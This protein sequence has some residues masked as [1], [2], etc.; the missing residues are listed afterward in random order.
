[1]SVIPIRRV[2]VATANSVLVNTIPGLDTMIDYASPAIIVYGSKSAVD[3]AIELADKLESQ[4]DFIVEFVQLEKELP[5]EVV[6]AFAK[7]EPRVVTSYDR[8][9][10]KLFLSG[11][12]A[13][14]A[15]LK[16][17]VAEI[18]N[19]T[20][21]EK[22]GVYYLDVD[23]ELPGEIQDYIRR[24]VPGVELNFHQSS[25]RFTIIGTPTEQLATA[26]LITD[27][28]LNLP[29]EDET[30]YYKL[31][32]QAP[33]RLIE[34]LR[35]RVKNVNTIERDQYNSATLRVVAK[36]FQHE[37]IAR[38]LKQIQEEYPLA[39]QNYFVA[40]K[41]TKEVRDR[42]EQIKDDWQRDKGTIK[43]LKDDA[44]NSF[45]VWA[46]PAQHKALKETLEQL[47]ELETGER[48]TA[49]LYSP[50]YVDAAT[51]VTILND[52]HPNVK[53]TNDTLNARIILR[54]TAQELDE[55]KAT[56]ATVDARG[57]DGVERFFKSYPVQGFYSYDSVGNYFSP[58]Y[59]I[60]DLSKL[61]PA[62][63]VTYDYYNQAVVVWGT[64]E[65]QDIMQKAIDDLVK[66]NDLDKR[67]LRWPVRRARYAT[68]I[69]Q[70]AA[71]Y[72]NAT[73]SYDSASKT[74][75]VRT[76][77]VVT[78]D[79]VKELLEILDPEEISEF[80]PVLQYYDVGAAPSDDLV[81]A[82]KALAPAAQLVQV[83]K[84]TKQLLVIATPAEH[85]VVAANV[86]RIAKTFGSSDLRLIPYPIYSM[87]VADVVASLTDAYP[88]A[89]FEADTRG[90]RVLARATLEDHVKISEEIARL[91]ADDE[92]IDET[93]ANGAKTI[94]TPGPRV[95]VYDLDSMA[96]ATQTRGVVT[97]LFPDAEIFGGTSG[98]G[99]L[100]GAP[101]QKQKVTIIANSREQKMIASIIESL[102]SRSDDDELLFAI[103]PFAAIDVDTIDSIVGNLVPDAIQI[104]VANGAMPGMRMQN[105]QFMMEQRYRRMNRGYGG[106]INSDDA[107]PFY[108]IDP[109][110]QTVALFAKQESHELVRESIDKL[111]ATANV[112]GDTTTK[113]YRLGAPIASSVAVA[114]AQIAPACVATATDGYELIVYGPES[115]FEKIDAMVEEIEKDKYYEARGRMKLFT[116]PEAAKYSRDRMVNIINANFPGASAYAGAVGNQI[117][118]WGSEV[119]LNRIENFVNTITSVPNEAVYKTYSLKHVDVST[120]VL[121]LTKVCPNLEI[122]PDPARVA[123]VIY[124][125][126]LQHSEVENAIKA[127]DQPADPEAL[128]KVVSY[129]WDDMTSYWV[130]YQELR[131]NFPTISIAP[132]PAAQQFVIYAPEPQHDQIAIYFKERRV[133][134]AQ[135]T[136]VFKPYYLHNIGYTRLI[137]ITPSVLPRVAI[138]PGKGSNEIFV[139]ASELD[140]L[141]FQEMLAKMESMPTEEERE[142]FQPKIYKTSATAAQVAIGILAPQLPGVSMYALTG[143]RFIAWGGLADHAFIEKSLQTIG[144]AF[145]EAVVKKYPLI[146]LRITDVISFLTTRYAGQAAFYASSS[147]D[148]MCQGPEI[149]QAEV[150]KLLAELDVEPP[151]ESRYTAV[152]YDISDIP[153][154]SHPTVVA[155]IA[156]V[157]PEALQ[158]P[159]STPGFLVIYARPAHHKKI[160]E[161]IDELLLERP[162]ARLSMRTYSVRR[163]T[164]AQLSQLLLPLYPNIKIGAGAS[165]YEIIITAKPSEH[166]KIAELISQLNETRDDGMTAKV[167]RLKNSQLA[168]ARSAI[169]TMYPQ[170]TVVIDQ[171]SRSVLV[172]AYEDEHKK[173]EQLVKEIDEKDPERNTSFKV[174]NIGNI[175]FTRVLA[176]LQNFYTG[177]PAFRVELDSYQRCIIV[178]GTAIQHEAVEKLIEEIRAGGM[179]DPDAYMQAYTVKNSSAYSSLYSIFYEI[180]SGIDMYRDYSTGKLIVFGREDDHKLVQNVLDLLA[181]EDT[182]LAIFPLLYVD[183]QTARQVFSMIET[184][185]TYVDVRFDANSNQLFV[186]A[187]PTLLEQIRRVL[188][189]MGEKDLEKMKPFAETTK[190]GAA[191]TNGKR[192]YLRDNDKKQKELQ[193]AENNNAAEAPVDIKNL[194]KIEITQPKPTT[195]GE[196]PKLQVKEGDGPIRTVT[197]DGGNTS[198]IIEAAIKQWK[199]DNPVKVVQGDGGIVQTKEGAANNELPAP[200]QPAPTPAPAPAPAPEMPAPT[201][202][203]A[204]APEQPAPAPEQPV[205]APAP[206]PERAAS[207]AVD[208]LT[209]AFVLAARNLFTLKTLA[210]GALVSDEP[211]TLADNPSE[212]APQVDTHA[213]TTQAATQTPVEGAVPQAPGV[214]VVVNPD[215]SILLS[216]SDENALEE[217]Q[218][219]LTNVVEGMKTQYEANREGKTEENVGAEPESQPTTESE[220]EPAPLVNVMEA[221]DDPDSPKYL[222]YMTEENLAK[223]RERVL[224]ESRQYTVYKVENVGVSQIVPRLQTYLADRINVNQT[225]RGR[226]GYGYGSGYGSGYDYDYYGG[227]SGI[228][229]RTITPPTQLSFREDPALNT[230][231]VFGS[232]ADREAV[233]AMLVLLDDVNLFPQPITK[234]YKIKVENTSALRMAQQVLNAFSRKF[235]TTLMPGNLTPRISPN[236][237]TNSL[238]VYA[239]EELAKEIEEYVNEVDKEILEESVRKVRVIELKSINSKTLATYMQHLRQQQAPTG[240]L[241]TPYI[242]GQG[243]FPQGGMYGR[244]MTPAYGAAA[245]ARA[246]GLQGVAPAPPR[247]I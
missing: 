139:I 116:L 163:M 21:D 130:I 14:V 90:S 141:K 148:L 101:G 106:G 87:K 224:L 84:K 70:I 138:Y 197:I 105:R 46:L 182:E 124:G 65:E 107:V 134:N 55:A 151:E 52:L 67:L 59:Y 228:T 95:V 112:G 32:A 220:N 207:N 83:D 22:D 244:A 120:A 166:E 173:I 114:L 160:R 68:L 209:P 127:F 78:L 230:L 93:N 183:S 147:G 245:R 203:P 155:N 210:C 53:V 72:P 204:P 36:P 61:V 81:D 142:G 180:G 5:N 28:I 223:A 135:M 92:E 232:K 216:S 200:E 222:S 41:T 64:Q 140:H 11:K 184:D 39:D 115:E 215:G 57:E 100:G 103:Y 194:E 8:S 122:T 85:K 54:G 190:G 150:A 208:L 31:D 94:N 187:T 241:S 26:K 129:T 205:P 213:E 236:P 167:Y 18:E 121:F 6:S 23:R 238:E 118:V 243:I 158:L 227:S 49:S 10:M 181:Q 191:L 48:N 196:A 246:Q 113:V 16:K 128:P 217:F 111:L 27:A 239:P 133:E 102:N 66:K 77:N 12:P 119:V 44:T 58:T 225:G 91:N 74:L 157:E 171:L 175:N 186:R 43:I 19:A 137:G 226:N 69:A 56:L 195:P 193:N 136:F 152:A 96:V 80:D 168:V 177:D 202:G 40:Y 76:N 51:L 221:S 9:N 29:P 99:Y 104:P 237:T 201:S 7:I 34:M 169:M 97:S 159:T 13:D 63:R 17:Y 126:P 2:A 25:K 35:E 188:I 125:T 172:K 75:L 229:M 73:P 176:A 33:D 82:V 24:A 110:T 71:I 199:R 162:E 219:N 3:A 45:A 235:Q 170:T 62:A 242:G 218:R 198:E 149:I 145:P 211:Q 185:G 20:T 117:I 154:A 38:A 240:M 79:A 179:A 131:S 98:S 156:R 47:A 86:E 37:E 108:R 15:R 4:L 30:R 146:H 165:E 42:F 143:D 109:V 231:M 50:K 1:M 206:T 212:P 164:L 161:V 153:V 247:G 174:F 144:E 214:Y 233:G 178:R 60:R 89:T 132:Y 123:L 192:L 88:A 234:P 189:Q